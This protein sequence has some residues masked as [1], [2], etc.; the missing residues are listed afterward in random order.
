MI[1]CKKI[2]FSIAVREE[3]VTQLVI[4]GISFLKS[5]ILALGAELVVKLVISGILF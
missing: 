5:I 1:E 3:L 4:S 2:L